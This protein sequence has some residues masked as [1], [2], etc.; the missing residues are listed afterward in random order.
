VGEV[1][2]PWGDGRHDWYFVEPLGGG[3][4]RQRG[5]AAGGYLV[6]ANR[7]PLPDWFPGG[8]AFVAVVSGYATGATEPR[9]PGPVS[10][11]GATSADEVWNAA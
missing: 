4:D 10:V 11:L 6:A 5:W 2:G 3:H 7:I 1:D 9:R 8:R